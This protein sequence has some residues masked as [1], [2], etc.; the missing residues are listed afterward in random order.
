VSYLWNE[1]QYRHDMIWKLTFRITAVAAA[2]L[3][4]PFLAEKS[5][6]EAVGKGLLALPVLAIVVIGGGLVVLQ[7]ELHRLGLIRKAY[8][9][10]QLEILGPYLETKELKKLEQEPRWW[11]SFDFRVFLYFVA[12]L[13][14][15]GIYLFAM[16]VWWLPDLD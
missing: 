13:V 10:A 12:L 16:L 6:H 15:A 11:Y 14:A 8:R 5:V 2:L 7:S 1:Y 3:I 9:Q 4:A